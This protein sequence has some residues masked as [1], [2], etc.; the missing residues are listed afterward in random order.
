V[1]VNLLQDFL[2]LF[3]GLGANFNPG[4]ARV[5]LTASDPDF[6]D[7]KRR[8]VGEDLVE[9]FGQEQ[10]IDDVPVEFNLFDERRGVGGGHGGVSLLS[11]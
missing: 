2:K 4:M 10:R 6:L 1:F 9:H 11:A 7:G 5:G 8:A 3:G